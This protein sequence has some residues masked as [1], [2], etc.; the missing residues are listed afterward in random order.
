MLTIKP[1]LWFDSEA[2]DAAKLYTSIFPG[3]EITSVVARPEGVLDPSR[4]IIVTFTIA[5]AVDRRDE[6]RVW[7]HPHTDAFSLAVEVDTQAELDRVWDRLLEGGGKPIACGWLEGS[8][9]RELAGDAEADD[10][11]DGVRRSQEAAAATAAAM[12]TMVK[13]DLKPG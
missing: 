7:A 2:E 6:R 10:H 1:F 3:S 8:L 13:L 12:M 4:V 9:R 11:L 5:G